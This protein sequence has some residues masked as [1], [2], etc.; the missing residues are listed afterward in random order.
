MDAGR[1]E[2]PLSVYHALIHPSGGRMLVVLGEDSKEYKR[3]GFVEVSETGQSSAPTWLADMSPKQTCVLATSLAQQTAFILAHETD[4]SISLRALRAEGPLQPVKEVYRA[5]LPAGVRLARDPSSQHV[6][7]LVPDHE[8]LHVVPLGP[9]PPVFPPCEPVLNLVK[10]PGFHNGCTYT[11]TVGDDMWAS[12]RELRGSTERSAMAWIQRQ[13][14]ASGSDIVELLKVYQVL[15][16]AD[17]PVV[18][19][20]FIDWMQENLPSDPHLVALRAAE[21]ATAQRWAQ[22]RSL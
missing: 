8:R 18:R 14:A 12:A 3:L 21:H 9:D 1:I 20:K 22:V 2:F 13:I 16:Y 7:A 10:V 6:V 11:I 19:G 4:H 17:Q 15:E 5:S